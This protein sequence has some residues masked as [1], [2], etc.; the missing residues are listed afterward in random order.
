MA[1]I[2]LLAI[3]SL[4][5]KNI[6]ICPTLPV[7]VSPNVLVEEVRARWNLDHGGRFEEND[8]ILENEYCD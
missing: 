1:V 5:I 8:V 7:F 4:G 6:H 2:V 3:L